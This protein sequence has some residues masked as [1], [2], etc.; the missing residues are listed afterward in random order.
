MR[1]FKKMLLTAK[2]L[3][4]GNWPRPL[5]AQVLEWFYMSFHKNNQNKFI[6]AGKKRKTK[7]FESVSEFFEAQ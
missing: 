5:E 1:Q 3:L 7:T 6:S 4:A 2:A